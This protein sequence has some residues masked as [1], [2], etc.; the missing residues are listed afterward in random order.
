M[1]VPFRS[2]SPPFFEL[3]RMHCHSETSPDTTKQFPSSSRLSLLVIICACSG[4]VGADE[5]D[6]IQR[7]SQGHLSAINSITLRYSN[8]LAVEFDE[9]TR[10][11][12]SNAGAGSVAADHQQTV[13]VDYAQDGRR[14]RHDVIVLGV[15]DNSK[16][17]TTITAFDG[18]EWQKFSGEKDIL[19]LSAEPLDAIAGESLNPF[20]MPYYGW[21][22][23][24]EES[25]MDLITISS[26]A[27]WRRRF[28]DARYLG[29]T[30]IAGQHCKT[31]EFSANT[32]P[33]P[34]GPVETILRVHFSESLNYYPIAHE[35][36]NADGAR[37]VHQFTV[38]K[39][40]QY[41]IGTEHVVLPLAVQ[42][43]T[44]GP[45]SVSVNGTI[46]EDSISINPSIEPDHFT[47]PQTM[48]R[49]VQR[50]SPSDFA[51]RDRPPSVIG[52][53]SVTKHKWFWIV[54]N[55]VIILVLS[56]ICF[57]RLRHRKISRTSL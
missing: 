24:N 54:I 41:E 16:A 34:D 6:E 20:L 43:V 49:N 42:S 38:V 46:R 28:A 27:V 29:K 37:K 2:E 7:L 33:G 40:R 48:A 1:G 22:V 47:L 39:H 8:V 52:I 18:V 10:A 12:L 5:L 30:V 31:V 14:L 19:A 57:W 15:D 3:P 17:R 44:N 55:L 11:A 35:R 9:A 56:G 45:T 36:L 53:S 25:V 4:P 50:V 21:L 23:P 32:L 13:N 26:D 51:L